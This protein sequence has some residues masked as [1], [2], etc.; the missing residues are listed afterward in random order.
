M[1]LFLKKKTKIVVIGHL[2][3]MYKA[4]GLIPSTGGKKSLERG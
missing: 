4:L 3:S 2:L 1:R